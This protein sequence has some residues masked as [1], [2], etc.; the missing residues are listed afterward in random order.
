MT[1][2]RAPVCARKGGAGQ[3]WRLGQR[4][5]GRHN[6][7]GPERRDYRLGDGAD[8]DV[9]LPPVD[10]LY[11][12]QEARGGRTGGPVRGAPRTEAGDRAYAGAL[13]R[14]WVPPPCLGL[15]PGI[16]V[17]RREAH[18][19]GDPPA[20]ASTVRSGRRAGPRSGRRIPASSCRGRP[21]ACPGSQ[22]PGRHAAMISS[23]AVMQVRFAP[24]RR[25]PLPGAPSKP[26]ELASSRTAPRPMRPSCSKTSVA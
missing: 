2:A 22:R 7:I 5:P 23:S 26:T 14:V 15:S 4:R 25:V 11:R 6:D 21:V 10:I 13:I 9:A 16:E 18:G 3:A 24:G 19:G 1:T 8:T 12:R 20:T 17:D